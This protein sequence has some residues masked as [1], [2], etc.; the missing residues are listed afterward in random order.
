MH[1]KLLYLSFL[2]ICVLLSAGEQ[3]APPF[4]RSTSFRHSS[5]LRSPSFKNTSPG[6]GIPVLFKSSSPFG[7]LP[8]WKNPSPSRN[9]SP[10]S[11]LPLWRTSGPWSGSQRGDSSPPRRAT[12]SNSSPEDSHPWRSSSPPRTPSPR[13]KTPTPF[14]TEADSSETGSPPRTPSPRFRT[15]TPFSTEGDSGETD[16]APPTDSASDVAASKRKADELNE[17][18]NNAVGGCE[19]PR[20]E[21]P[22]Y[23]CSGILIRG[24]SSDRNPYAWTLSKYSRETMSVCMGYLRRDA[25]WAGFPYGYVSGFIMYPQSKTPWTKTKTGVI[26]AFPLDA[27]SDE[28]TGKYACGESQQDTIGES[29]HCHA[30][31]IFSFRDWLAHYHRVSFNFSHTQCGFDMTA[32][33]APG[34]FRT[35]LKAS[36]FVQNEPFDL[37]NNEILVYAWNENDVARIPIEAFFFTVGSE[38]GRLSARRF[39][40]DFKRASGGETIPIVGIQFPKPNVREFKVYPMDEAKL[41]TERIARSTPVNPWLMRSPS[42]GGSHDFSSLFAS[43]SARG[44]SHDFASL[45]ANHSDRGGSHDFSSL[46]ANPSDRGGSHDFASLFAN[47]SARGGFSPRFGSSPS[48]R[49]IMQ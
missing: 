8:L 32:P 10:L 25:Q 37:K 43:P 45:F 17:R 27:H 33:Q 5:P 41:I 14:S 31:G 2:S 9:P 44:G 38:E 21:S 40:R 23:E 26:C 39:Q 6:S 20:G 42:R 19:G 49:F 1:R 4:P 36:N 22:A 12:W 18:F 15:P 48:N 3:T 46:F 16:S 30:Q 7:D 47:P 35:F 11:D 13:F 28:R 34:L 29:G 24:V